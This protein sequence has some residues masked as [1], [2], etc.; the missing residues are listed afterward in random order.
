MV[1]AQ[2]AGTY[3]IF[4]ESP[5][6][7]RKLI[8]SAN[9]FWWSPGGSSE[10][11]IANTPEKWNFLPV[12]AAVGGP[13]Y[14]IVF[15]INAGAAAT[16]DASDSAVILPIQVWDKETRTWS[17][18]TVGNEDHASGLG[19]DNFSVDRSAADEALIANVDTP[20]MVLRAREGVFFR[21]GGDR[22]SI[23]WENNA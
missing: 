16:L 20:E 9:A 7:A 21:V 18:Q 19:N 12:H 17:S 11:T 8:K 5:S 14:K 13:G 1:S 23:S 3:K 10:G 22:V 2:V 6:G 15:V 4:M